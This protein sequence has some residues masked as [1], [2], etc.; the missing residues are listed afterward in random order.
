MREFVYSVKIV[1]I[2]RDVCVDLFLDRIQN[3]ITWNLVYR[4]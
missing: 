1:C 2:Q 3:T 4:V